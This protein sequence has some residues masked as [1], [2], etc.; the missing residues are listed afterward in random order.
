MSDDMTRDNGLTNNG[1]RK[2][3]DRKPED[4]EIG[5]GHESRASLE[6]KELGGGGGGKVADVK[7]LI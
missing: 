5:R 4:L 3:R 7:I 6:E 1:S 2:F